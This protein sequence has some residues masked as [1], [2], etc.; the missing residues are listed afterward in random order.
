MDRKILPQFNDLTQRVRKLLLN[1]L[2]QQVRAA[3]TEADSALFKETLNKSQ[4]G[5]SLW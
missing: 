5:C 4:A 1:H 3:F 2:A